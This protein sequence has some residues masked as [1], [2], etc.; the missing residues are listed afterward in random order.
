MIAPLVTGPRDHRAD[1]ERDRRHVDGT[2]PISYAFRWQQCSKAGTECADI[3]GASE[4]KYKIANG[5]AAHTLRVVVTAKNV[6]GTTEKESLTT[7]EVLGVGPQ[8][9]EAPAS[10]AKPKK[11]SC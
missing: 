4:S 7:T 6:A 2:A 3:G 5:D 11:A 9:T 1:A 8:N 10:P